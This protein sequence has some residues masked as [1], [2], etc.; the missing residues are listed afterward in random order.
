MAT[1]CVDP[2]GLD[3]TALG[4]WLRNHGR[5]GRA[6]GEWVD[7]SVDGA[8]VVVDTVASNPGA[9]ATG[10]AKGAATG[11]VVGAAA[12]A[13]V[14]A[15]GPAAPVVGAIVFTIFTAWAVHSVNDLAA[16]WNDMTPEQQAAA[17]GELGGGIIGSAVGAKAAARPTRAGAPTGAAPVTETP[18]QIAVT[19]PETTA[20][21]SGK[22]IPKSSPKFQP[23][24]NSPQMPPTEI[25][26]C[27]RI[28]EMPPT[29]QYPDGYGKLEKPMKDGSWQPTNP[30]TMKP[31]TRPETH[32]PFPS[33]QGPKVCEP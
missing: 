10:A 2:M 11:V 28:R 21:P 26:P 31:G 25:P 4:R 12:T 7:D 29:A 30:S 9:A 24:T 20:P 23:P 8:K 6:V 22:G 3:G 15:S 27:W 18:S 33:S 19:G 1:G 16:N 17:L 5:V 14:E 13:V 32:V